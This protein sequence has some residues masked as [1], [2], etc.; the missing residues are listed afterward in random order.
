MTLKSNIVFD[1]DTSIEVFMD[2]VREVEVNHSREIVT[3]QASTVAEV[4]TVA[5]YRFPSI[6]QYR[7]TLQ[8]NIIENK[9]KM[10]YLNAYADRNIVI[11]G[12]NSNA[13]YGNVENL[14]MANQ[15]LSACMV[16]FT[17][18]AKG[19]VTGQF[20]DSDDCTSSGA[21]TADSDAVN[22]YADVLAAS[23]NEIG[24]TIVQSDVVLPEGDYKM[25]VRAKDTAAV[26]D[27]LELLVG[28]TTDTTTL[29]TD[30]Y[31]L[32]STYQ[33]YILDFTVASD[34]LGDSIWIA[35]SKATATANSISIDFVGFVKV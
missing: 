14:R 32:T 9:R 17:T 28:N 3:Y 33:Y 18:Q 5:R 6:T 19:G 30:T 13:I 7:G 25:Y 22:G 24:F 35:A 27:D 29:A 15:N 12:G 4:K 23:G 21:R 31:T 11:D 2:S 8:T 16:E 34:D 1:P 10:I 26:A 20:Y